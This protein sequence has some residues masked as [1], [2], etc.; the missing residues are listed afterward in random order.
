MSETPPK[1]FRTFTRIWLGQVLSIFG[2]R[3]SGFAL[4]VWVFQETSSVLSFTLIAAIRALAAVLAS[5]LAGVLADRFDRK[6][7]M[8]TG[9][10][11]AALGTALLFWLFL[12]D[13]LELWHIYVIGAWSAV[14][15]SFQ[16]PAFTASIALLVPRVHLARANGMVSFGRSGAEILAPLAAGF[17]L[18][19][20]R[21]GGI[22]VLDLAS[23]AFAVL[24]LAICQVP[25]PDTLGSGEASVLRQA[26]EGWDAI[27][28]HP[29]LRG[30]LGY[31]VV[32]N[33]FLPAAMILT[34]PLVLSFTSA[35][36]LGLLL[37]IG[38]AGSLAGGLV[39]SAWGGPEKKVVGILGF[40]PLLG[41]GLIVIGLRP[42]APLIGFGLLMLFFAVPLVNGC[43]QA[44]WQVKI[45]PDLQGRVF[46]TQRTLSMASVPVALFVAGPLAEK[47]FEPLLLPAG[48][49]AASLGSWLG[50][51]PG[52]GTG[53][54]FV[55]MGLCSLACTLWALGNPRLRCL[56]AEI[57]DAVTTA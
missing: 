41:L 53:L 25:R 24:M 21:L 37:A 12:A 52:R 36:V 14:C 32:L 34:T 57:P 13:R 33:L 27:W 48:R 50:T 17:L 39:M 35:D 23:F 31:F 22:F 19:K 40:A 55:L 4:G 7:L 5:P 15:S 6:R 47:L 10:V 49:F 3:L 42:S 54:F 56:E 26:L 44:I 45:R 30:L 38:S 20:I 28:R 16:Y 29:G 8:V 11:G 2:S 1:G 46:A 43:A 9:D 51:G 18:A